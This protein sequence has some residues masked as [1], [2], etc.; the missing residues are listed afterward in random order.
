[1]LI[2]LF[3]VKTGV[4]RYTLLYMGQSYTVWSFY[5]KIVSRV[6]LHSISRKI[7]IYYNIIIMKE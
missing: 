3:T 1:M 2:I 4:P 6:T 5:M 7:F